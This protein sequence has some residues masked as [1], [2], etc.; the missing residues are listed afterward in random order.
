MLMQLPTP[1]GA[2]PAEPG[3]GGQRDTL[4]LG[5]QRYGANR[6]VGL[7]PLDEPRMSGIRHVADLT[8]ISR[9]ER[10]EYLV[11]P[12]GGRRGIGQ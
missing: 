7:H 9:P 4:L 1:L 3:A 8:N 12:I 11:A 10:V 6:R 2:L 5:S